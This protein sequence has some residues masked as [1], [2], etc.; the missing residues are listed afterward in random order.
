MN[1]VAYKQQL[2]RLRCPRSSHQ[3]FDIQWACCL[4]HRWHFPT[5]L[6]KAEDTSEF[7]TM[8]RPLL[9]GTNH[10]HEALILVA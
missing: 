5:H 1:S 2:W 7:Q 9:Q 3:S 8:K 10:I 4:L 6:R